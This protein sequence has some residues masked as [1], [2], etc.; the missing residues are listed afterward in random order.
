MYVDKERQIN[1]PCFRF[2]VDSTEDRAKTA[3]F[4]LDFEPVVCW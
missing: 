3:E 4:F 1:Q 2:L